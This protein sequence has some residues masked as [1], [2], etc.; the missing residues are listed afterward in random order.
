M[1]RRK[2]VMFEVPEINEPE[3]TGKGKSPKLFLKF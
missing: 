1:L 3:N 2:V